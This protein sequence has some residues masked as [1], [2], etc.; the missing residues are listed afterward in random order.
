MKKDIK[1]DDL[2][3]DKANRYYI[4]M[5]YGCRGQSIIHEWTR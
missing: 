3:Y 1:N 5:Y 4:S 2:L